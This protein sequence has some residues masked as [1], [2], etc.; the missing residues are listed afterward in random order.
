[1]WSCEFNRTYRYKKPYD[2]YFFVQNYILNINFIGMNLFPTQFRYDTYTFNINQI[3]ETF[4]NK[5]S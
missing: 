3:I 2:F 4:T 1:M 5:N